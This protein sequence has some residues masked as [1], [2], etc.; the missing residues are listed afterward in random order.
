MGFPAKCMGW[1]IM[2][3]TLNAGLALKWFFKNV[4]EGKKYSDVDAEVAKVSPC[5]GGLVFLPYLTGDRTPHLDPYA[6]G[7]FF[8]MRLQHNSSHLLRAVMEG[9]TFALRDSMEIFKSMNIKIDKVIASG[10]GAKSKIWQQMQ[11]D[12]FGKPIYTT[13]AAE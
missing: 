4:L 5:S 10:G 9:V 13:K 6:R 11:A 7:V 8:G 3:A 2:G 1:Y 12:I